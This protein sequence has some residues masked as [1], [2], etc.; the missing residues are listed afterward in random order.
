MTTDKKT[1][2]ALFASG[3]GS[4]VQNIIAYFDKNETIEV[5]LVLSNKSNAGALNHAR[6]A[7]ITCTSFNQADFFESNDVL[8][9]LQKEKIDYIILAGFLWKVPENILAAF[10]TKILNIHPSLLPKYGGKGMYG[11][12]VHKAVL[13]DKETETGITIHLV[14]EKYDDGA[15]IEQVKCTIDE[16]ET[17]ASLQEKIS[18]LEKEFFPITIE[19][20]INKK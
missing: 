13:S 16:N 5:R 2:I 7:S 15:I 14:N 6:K 1:K 19:N 8:R 18:Q 3:T 4:N 11:E 10:D 12:L 20:Y 17:L 9:L